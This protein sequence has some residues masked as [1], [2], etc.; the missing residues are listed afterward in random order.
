MLPR[1]VRC[2]LC[3]IPFLKESRNFKDNMEKLHYMYPEERIAV[4]DAKKGRKKWSWSSYNYRNNCFPSPSLGKM[5]LT[6]KIELIYWKI[7]NVPFRYFVKVFGFFLDLVPCKKKY[8]CIL[9][10]NPHNYVRNF[11]KP[12]NPAPITNFLVNSYYD[13]SENMRSG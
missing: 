10:W 9:S 13:I 2:L 1:F 7:H 5:I 6:L 4:K 3:D 11:E 12:P 8:L